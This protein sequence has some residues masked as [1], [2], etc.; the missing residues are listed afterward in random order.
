MLFVVFAVIGI[1]IG[2]IVIRLTRGFRKNNKPKLVILAPSIISILVAIIIMYIGNVEIEGIDGAAYMLLS[3]IIFCFG[4]TVFY[5]A[6]KKG[7]ER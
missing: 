7:S 6:D 1:L 4:V 5:L 3:L 2:I